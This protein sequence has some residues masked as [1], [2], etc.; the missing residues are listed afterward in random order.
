[1]LDMFL[2]NLST[3]G[4]NGYFLVILTNALCRHLIVTAIFAQAMSCPQ[5]PYFKMAASASALRLVP[6]QQ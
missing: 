5:L 3:F 4:Y 1:M 2:F 6:A